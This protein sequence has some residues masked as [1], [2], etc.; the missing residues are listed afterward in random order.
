MKNHVLVDLETVGTG[1]NA[2]LLSIGA[3]RFDNNG[4]HDTFYTN[5]DPLDGIK[6]GAKADERTMAWWKSQPEE[7]QKLMILDQQQ[8]IP[9]LGK[10]TA[11]FNSVE[12]SYIWGFGP[13]FDC[14]ILEDNYKL[15]GLR[16]PWPYNK[17]RCGR[18]II[19]F[20]PTK[21]HKKERRPGHYEHHALYDAIYEAGQIVAILKELNLKLP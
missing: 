5:L 13:S 17:E 4:L 19:Q 21:K 15:C 6:H 14:A 8:L 9:S 20:D 3:V 2:A 11:W 18:T 10:F 7:L 16:S 12:K 1:H